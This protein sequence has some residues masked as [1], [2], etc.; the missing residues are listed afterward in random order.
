MLVLT[1]ANAGN[2]KIFPP[3]SVPYGKTYG[4]WGG[5]YNNWV[6]HYPFAE[7]PAHATSKKNLESNS[8]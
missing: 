1:N 4:A 3:N 8:I 2:P 7:N 5:D 6:W